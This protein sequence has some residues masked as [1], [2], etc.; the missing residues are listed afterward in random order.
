MAE[1][2]SGEKTEE[3]TPKKLEDERKQGNVPKSIDMA[4]FIALS[5]ALLGFAVFFSIICGG[6]IAFFRYSFSHFGE[7]LGLNTIA[8]IAL[9]GAVQT[10]KLALPI[11]VLVAL[12]G[13][14]GYVLQFGLLF[15]VKPLQPD[16]KKINP[17]KGLGNLFS[18]QKFLDGFKITAKVVIAM[19]VAAKLLWGYIADLPRIQTLPLGYQIGWLLEKSIVIALV[20][21]LVF[22]FF[23]IADLMIVR[24]FYFK[25]AR[26]SKQEIRDEF[27]NTEGNPEVRAR[28][29]RIQ[30]EMSRRRMMQDIPKASV[31]VTNPTHFAVALKYDPAEDRVP[32][33]VAKGADTIAM[34]IKEIAREHDI[35]IVELPSLARQLYKEL[36]IG[37]SIPDK[38]FEAVVELFTYVYKLKGRTT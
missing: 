38:L 21:L 37:E 33:V 19:L 11:A 2:A 8:D 7:E 26:M 36:D 34:K 3:A 28:I 27:K 20:M 14:L 24:Y 1:D 22:F 32:I 29:R 17:I 31:V 15:S 25:R 16:I 4:G 30:M 12:F 23:A 35:P 6:L 9:M 13:A 5:S 10:L 18:M